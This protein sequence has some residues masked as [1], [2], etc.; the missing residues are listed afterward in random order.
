VKYSFDSINFNNFTCQKISKSSEETSF[1]KNGN[2]LFYGKKGG[3]AKLASLP[4]IIHL[5]KN[6]TDENK[7]PSFIKNKNQK[8]QIL[9]QKIDSHNKKLSK[10]LFYLFLNKISFGLYNRKLEH[11]LS[12]PEPEPEQKLELELEQEVISNQ[13][14]SKE[15]K[16]RILMVIA[17]ML[18]PLKLKKMI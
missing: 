6:Q 7:N 4:E 15:S 1:Y 2:C 3:G 14:N 9:N 12:E 8:I 16:R 5:F 11:L 10:N 17:L 18:K 13:E